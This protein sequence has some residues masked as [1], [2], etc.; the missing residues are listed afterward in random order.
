MD[1]RPLTPA[2]LDAALELW[3]R[4]EHLGPVPRAEVEGLLAHDGDLVLGAEEAG[5]LVGVV[6][7]SYDGRRGWIQR[8]AIDD[9]HRRRGVGRALIA[10]VER[11]LA[12][13]GCVQVNLLVFEDNTEGRAFW[14]AAGY[15]GD[16]GLALYRRRLDERTGDVPGDGPA[17]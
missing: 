13:R 14:E 2:D 3:D 15:D 4:T 10:E 12:A 8:L 11:R 5:V 16:G 7:G 17:C 6:L 9:D 1:L